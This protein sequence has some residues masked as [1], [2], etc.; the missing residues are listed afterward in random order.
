[1]NPKKIEPGAWRIEEDPY[2]TGK[3]RLEQVNTAPTG[4]EYDEI[5]VAELAAACKEFGIDPKTV[6]Y[7]CSGYHGDPAK[8]FPNSKV[9]FLDSDPFAIELLKK[10]NIANIIQGDALKYRPEEEIDLVILQNPH[11]EPDFPAHAVRE[12]GYVIC[13]NYHSTASKMHELKDFNLL[14]LVKSGSDEKPMEII[15]DNPN[16]YLPKQS[17]KEMDSGAGQFVFQRKKV[18][19]IE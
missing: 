9:I 17:E 7:P 13:N 10:G 15:K 5:F 18:L 14:G 4:P 8:A 11:I 1:M 12:G 3:E 16:K 2:A 19:K 6:Y